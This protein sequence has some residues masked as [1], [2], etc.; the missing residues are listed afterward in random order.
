LWIGVGLG[1]NGVEWS[2]VKSSFRFVS[3]ASLCADLLVKIG[4]GIKIKS[5][6]EFAE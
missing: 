3:K 6:Q 4:D 5:G 2:G 1:W